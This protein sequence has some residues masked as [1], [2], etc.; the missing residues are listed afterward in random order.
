MN[1]HIQNVQH[2]LSLRTWLNIEMAPH[3]ATVPGT[4]DYR[5]NL[6]WDNGALQ[7]KI[8]SL[9]KFFQNVDHARE[10]CF[11]LGIFRLCAQGCGRSPNL[12]RLL[13]CCMVMERNWTNHFCN[14][15]DRC[16]LR[17]KAHLMSIHSTTAQTRGLAKC[18]TFHFPSCH[19]SSTMQ[20]HPVR[21]F[22]SEKTSKAT[23]ISECQLLP[24]QWRK[25]SI[26]T[27]T[28][29]FAGFAEL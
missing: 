11:H 26:E 1:T 4:E 15:Q 28:Y 27:L 19:R 9:T 10:A 16:P 20:P 21:V 6:Q 5:H 18:C 12:R 3:R 2:I 17:K 7:N 25:A 23:I 8:F 24:S 22:M 13:E 14:T 29:D